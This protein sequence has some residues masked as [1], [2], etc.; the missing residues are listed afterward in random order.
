[1]HAKGSPSPPTTYRRAKAV[2]QPQ[3]RSSE[4]SLQ[5][6]QRYSGKVIGRMQNWET[7]PH[8]KGQVGDDRQNGGATGLS[9]VASNM[10]A[11]NERTMSSALAEFRCQAAC[12][13]IVCLNM[14]RKMEGLLAGSG[15]TVWM[16]AGKVDP[17]SPP[18]PR[19]G[20]NDS[21]TVWPVL[22]ISR[23]LPDISQR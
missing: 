20:R 7:L 14:R 16:A 5:R 19:L 15:T 10:T 3:Y 8:N 4:P 22:F 1:L 23:S 21:G 9:R 11:H 17:G 6:K 2:L 18:V 13:F 12:A